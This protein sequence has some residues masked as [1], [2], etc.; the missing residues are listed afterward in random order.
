[1]PAVLSDIRLL[2]VAVGASY[3]A[4]YLVAVR[5]IHWAARGLGR[6]PH[7]FAMR[8]RRWPHWRLLD[9]VLRAAL[10]L[11]Y[12]MLCLWRGY[13]TERDVGLLVLPDDASWP[14]L[15]SLVLGTMLWLALWWSLHGAPQ[16]SGKPDNA[17][18]PY[19]EGCVQSLVREAQAGIWRGAFTALVGTYWGVWLGVLTNGA[20]AL[21]NPR[22][23][24]R[25]LVQGQ[26]SFALLDLALDG[27]GAVLFLYTSS[28]PMGFLGRL[29]VQMALLPL[30]TARRRHP[31]AS[32]TPGPTQ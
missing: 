10:P 27:F 6:H 24:A 29:I 14:W 16:T 5:G 19:S 32:A 31:A 3:A 9:R 8:V 4:S 28:L 7:P 18:E 22:V 1:M 13:L 2:S 23:R 21:A 25:L 12:L 15:A 20:L 30:I 11:S 17:V 26:R